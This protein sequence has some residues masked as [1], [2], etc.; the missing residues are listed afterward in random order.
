MSVR[1]TED[2]IAAWVDGSL[3]E[4]DARRI[5]AAVASDPAAREIAR[6]IE[7]MNRALRDAFAETLEEE[8]PA[9]LKAAI[10]AEPGKVAAF[11]VRQRQTWFPSA[12]AAGV[13]LA[14]GLGAGATLFGGGAEAPQMTAALGV[15][16]AGPAV[17]AALETAPTGGGEGA[18]TPLASFRLAD[19]RWCREFETAEAAAGLACRSGEGAW[20]VQMIAAA[21]EATDGSGGYVPASG[22]FA[23]AIGAAL[24]AMDAGPVLSPDEEAA[25]IADGWR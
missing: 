5:E 21:P 19:G 8:P 16:P 22:A 13:A 18:V 20:T 7:E 9:T 23:D 3:D 1:W 4:D 15:G 2:E 24:D 17:A 25:A 11:P 6:Q 14:V 10:L 12:M